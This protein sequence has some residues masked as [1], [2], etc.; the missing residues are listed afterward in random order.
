MHDASEPCCAFIQVIWSEGT[1]V[2]VGQ[3]PGIFELSAVQQKFVRQRNTQSVTNMLQ[4]VADVCC[5][6]SS[7]NQAITLPVGFASSEAGAIT[8]PA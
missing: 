6:V 2:V 5:A 3:Q 1:V 8:W 4:V 7:I